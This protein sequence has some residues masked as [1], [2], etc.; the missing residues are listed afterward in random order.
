MKRLTLLFIAYFCLRQFCGV[1]QNTPASAWRP[2]ANTGL[3]GAAYKIHPAA[4][5]TRFMLGLSGGITAAPEVSGRLFGAETYF[6]M[7]QELYRQPE[8]LV[9][10]QEQLGAGFSFGTPSQAAAFSRVQASSERVFGLQATLA[11][12]RRWAVTLGIGKGHYTSGAAFPLTTFSHV[13]EPAGTVQGSAHTETNTLRADLQCRYY[14]VAAGPLR[15]F[16][17]AGLAYSRHRSSGLTASVDGT[18]WAVDPVSTERRY[19]AA[20]QAGLCVLPRNRPVFAEAG[21]GL[22]GKSG[23]QLQ[24]TVGWRM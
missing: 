6:R 24:G 17:G 7:Q 15:L 19:Q 20:A 2:L 21:I 8:R 22:R 1:A 23:W 18:S 5:F 11:L 14:F 12:Q 3:T 10:L 9:Q 4:G 16:A 13:N